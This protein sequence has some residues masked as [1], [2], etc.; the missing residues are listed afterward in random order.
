MND[1]IEPR[2]AADLGHVDDKDVVKGMAQAIAY[3]IGEPGSERA[4]KAAIGV[5]ADKL[6]ERALRAAL[7]PD[8]FLP[9]RE[10]TEAIQRYLIALKEAK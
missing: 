9:E 10:T 2:L 3:E 4:A 6:N 8:G 7:A 5:L 1:S